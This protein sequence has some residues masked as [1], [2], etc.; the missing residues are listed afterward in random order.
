MSENDIDKV[1]QKVCSQPQ[2]IASL[3]LFVALK[4]ARNY[5]WCQSQKVGK[6]LGQKGVA[7]WFKKHFSSWYRDQWVNHMYGKNFWEEFGEKEYNIAKSESAP[8]KKLFTEIIE[9]VSRYGENLGIIMWASNTGQNMSEVLQLLKMVDINNRRFEIEESQI[10]ALSKAL[11]E[12][13][14]YKWIESQ[15]AGRDLGEAAVVEWFRRYWFQYYEKMKQ[16]LDEC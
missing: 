2:A 4:E 12:A 14:K 11:D 9:S 13:D 5:K 7:D 10:K 1:C 6:D 15:K 16:S 3:L 8:C